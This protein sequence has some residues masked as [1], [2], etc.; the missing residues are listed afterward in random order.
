MTLEVLLGGEGEGLEFQAADV[1]I[2]HVEREAAVL[3]LTEGQ[4]GILSQ[5]VADVLDGFKI[6]VGGAQCLEQ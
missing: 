3:G 6:L 4:C 5:V 1:T 2:I